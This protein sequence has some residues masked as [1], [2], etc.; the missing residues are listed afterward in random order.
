MVLRT[1]VSP[2]LLIFYIFDPIFAILDAWL[3]NHPGNLGTCPIYSP[4]LIPRIRVSSFFRDQPLNQLPT[5]LATIIMEK[6]QKTC[7]GT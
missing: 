4:K 5:I 6:Y 1:S 3:Q 2:L 7:C